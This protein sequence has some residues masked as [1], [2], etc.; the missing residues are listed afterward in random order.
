MSLYRREACSWVSDY[1]WARDGN[2]VVC[3]RAEGQMIGN[4]TWRGG[5]DDLGF[6]KRNVQVFWARTR[7]PSTGFYNGLPLLPAS[8][9]MTYG[10]VSDISLRS[11]RPPVTRE[12]RV[13]GPGHSLSRRKF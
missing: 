2:H 11:P 8:P 12:R 13:P 9:L 3:I 5:C 1:G 7:S 6:N 10:D 4:E